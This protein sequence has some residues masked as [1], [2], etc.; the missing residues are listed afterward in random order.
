MT[1]PRYQI[2]RRGEIPAPREVPQRSGRAKY[3]IEPTADSLRLICGRLS[4][5]IALMPMTMGLPLAALADVLVGHA[6]DRRNTRP[7]CALS[8]SAGQESVQVREYG[9]CDERLV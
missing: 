2:F 5:I 8:L 7:G 6:V 9:S 1:S 3:V 4:L